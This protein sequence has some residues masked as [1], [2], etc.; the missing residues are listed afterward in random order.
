MSAENAADQKQK[1]RWLRR[2]EPEMEE[3]TESELERGITASKGRATPGRRSGGEEEPTGN[4][5]TRSAGGIGEYIEGVRSEL[6]KVTWPTR[7]ETQRLSVIVIVVTIIS[8]ILLGLISLGFTE[9]FRLGL[10]NPVIF[11]VFFIVVGVLAFVFY[12]RTQT[13]DSS[14]Y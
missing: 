9:L 13:D 6:A 7:E 12:Q 1:R 14:P 2:N 5:V 10:N 3:E 11:L 8:S 4:M